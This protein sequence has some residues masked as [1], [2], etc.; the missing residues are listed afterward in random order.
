MLEA[1]KQAALGAIDATGPVMV[2]MGRV[3]SVNPLK[4]I[5][6]NRLELT[7]DFLIIPE[8][9]TELKVNLRHTHT[10]GSGT[11]GEALTSPIIL[12][13]ALAADDKLLLL[14]MQG[15]QRYIILDRVVS[16]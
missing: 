9:L 2:Q 4:V 14:R 3:V 16:G 11:T 5:V 8:S 15:G 7:E 12:R 6:D 10:S 1:I 13:K